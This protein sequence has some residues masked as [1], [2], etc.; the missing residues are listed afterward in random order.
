M[1]PFPNFSFTILELFTWWLNISE[2]PSR[3]C[4]EM[5]AN[6]CDEKIFKEKL[7]HFASKTTEGKSEYFSYCKREHINIFE[8]M[9]D[10]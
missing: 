7:L 5:L 8:V 6:F 3:Y 1:I 9:R 10:F 4:C 2:P